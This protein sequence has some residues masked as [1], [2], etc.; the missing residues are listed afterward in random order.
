MKKLLLF[1]SLLTL[2]T[3]AFSQEVSSRAKAM[4]MMA[5]ARPE[6]MVKDVKV[7]TDTMTVYTLAD[8]V[9]YPFGKWTNIEQYITDNQLHW[10]RESGYKHY[11][12][13]MEVSVNT[14]KR[15]DGSFVDFYRSITT[16]NLEI[17]EALIT[18]KEVVFDNG[19]HPG[20]T[21]DETFAVLFKKYPK[22]YTADINVLKVISGAGEVGQVYTFKGNRLRHIK[23]ISKYKYY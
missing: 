7:Y 14:L 4:R 6:Y 10:Y 21:K 17:L 11:Y 16:G 23:V 8:Y 19:L 1:V 20:M 2:T 9:I 12:D 22:S 15:L 5:F 13:S 18:D 3:V